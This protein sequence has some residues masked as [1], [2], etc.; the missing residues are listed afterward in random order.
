MS[1][2]DKYIRQEELVSNLSFTFLVF[3]IV[4]LLSEN[5]FWVS[6]VFFIILTLFDIGKRLYDQ[7]TTTS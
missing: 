6:A 1:K 3:C 5:A 2:L 4:F 7:K